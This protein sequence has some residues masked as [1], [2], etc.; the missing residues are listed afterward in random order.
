MCLSFILLTVFLRK[1]R[2]EIIKKEYSLQE[3]SINTDLFSVWYTPI[4]L[5]PHRIR[6]RKRTAPLYRPGHR[7]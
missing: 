7:N 3:K 2:C 5:R 4:I 6:N 1:E